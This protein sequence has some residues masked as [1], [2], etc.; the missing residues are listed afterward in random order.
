M[1][2]TGSPARDASRVTRGSGPPGRWRR[3]TETRPSA[4]PEPGDRTAG[5]AATEMSRDVGLTASGNPLASWGAPDY[6][7]NVPAV[8]V[9]PAGTRAKNPAGTVP[10]KARM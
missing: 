4:G 2:W 7:D 6:H 10:V 8:D 5:S 3:A 9:I 1:P